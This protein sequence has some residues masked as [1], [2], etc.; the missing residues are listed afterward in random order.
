[1]GGPTREFF[2]LVRYGMEKYLEKTGCFKHNYT[3]C[4][5]KN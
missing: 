1:M 4:Q 2:R 3:A 5:V